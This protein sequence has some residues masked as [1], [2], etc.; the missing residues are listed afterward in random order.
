MKAFLLPLVIRIALDPFSQGNATCLSTR[1]FA[2]L[3]L[4]KS[5]FVILA[6]QS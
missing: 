1:N 4:D 6:S 2:M 5:F 3:F